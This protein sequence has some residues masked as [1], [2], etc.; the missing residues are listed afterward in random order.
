MLSSIL[1][2]LS[3]ANVVA[4]LALFVAL[5]GGA[6]AAIDLVGRNDI[7][8]RHVANN[9]LT[10]LD[11]HQ[12]SLSGRDIRERSLGRVPSATEAQSAREAET[13]ANAANATNTYWAVVDEDGDLVRGRSVVETYWWFGGTYLV[14]FASDTPEGECGAVAT[15]TPAEPGNPLLAEVWSTFHAGRTW[16]AVNIREA[17]QGNH[18]KGGFS[19]FMVCPAEED[20]AE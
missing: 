7:K 5:G 10:G 15:P 16:A 3:Y 8:S 18:V 14:D 11:V 19:L 2:R 17:S 13:A 12:N 1:S 9:S 4:T 6:Y 20:P